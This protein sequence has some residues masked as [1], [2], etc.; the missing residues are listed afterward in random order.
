MISVCSH[1]YRNGGL[2]I[3]VHRVKKFRND[4]TQILQNAFSDTYVVRIILIM[5]S[6]RNRTLVDIVTDPRAG[7]SG[8]QVPARANAQTVFRAHPALYQGAD[9]SLARPGRKQ[10]T[11]TKLLLSK[12]TQKKF[13]KLSVQPGLRGGNDLHVGRKMET[14]QFFFQSDRAKDVSALL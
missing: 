5:D 11:A 6:K 8:F 12:A 4:F 7:R 2:R 13:R 3:S 10:A 14:F 1:V 9:K